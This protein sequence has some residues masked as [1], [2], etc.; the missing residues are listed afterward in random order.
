MELC[1]KC[2]GNCICCSPN[3]LDK[4]THI[5]F[6]AK[7]GEVGHP[8]KFH[9]WAFNL[10]AIFNFF[11]DRSISSL[12]LLSGSLSNGFPVL[13]IQA[14]HL[15]YMIERIFGFQIIAISAFQSKTRCCSN[16]GI[17]STYLFFSIFFNNN[18]W[19]QIMGWLCLFVHHPLCCYFGIWMCA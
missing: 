11:I 15:F 12:F 9:L 19:L 8:F 5:S 10:V 17:V 4:Y 13:S 6:L 1:N 2:R 16:K 18:L 7:V 14:N 3:L